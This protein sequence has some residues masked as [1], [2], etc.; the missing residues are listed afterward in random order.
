MNEIITSVNGVPVRLNAER[1]FHITTGHPE[2]ADYYFE[3]LQTLET[4]DAVYE[5][6]RGELLAVRSIANSNGK[7]MIVVYR[8]VSLNDGFV[9]LAYMSSKIHELQKRTIVWQRQN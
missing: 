6:N 5:G 2:L 3:M 9:T 1:W 4:P 7:N 8:E